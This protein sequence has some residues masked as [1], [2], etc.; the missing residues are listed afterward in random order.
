MPVYIA[1]SDRK[2]DDVPGCRMD[3]GMPCSQMYEGIVISEHPMRLL[4]TK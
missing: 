2:G 4:I 1:E 3:I